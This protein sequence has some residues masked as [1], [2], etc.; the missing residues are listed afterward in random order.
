[1]KKH[2]GIIALNIFLF[3]NCQNAIQNIKKEIIK[4]IN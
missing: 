3:D 2:L 4:F 1:M